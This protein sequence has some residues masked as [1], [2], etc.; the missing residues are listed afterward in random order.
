MTLGEITGTIPVNE[1]RAACA[2]ARRAAVDPNFG[3]QNAVEQFDSEIPHD[4]ASRI[5]DLNETDADKLDLA[6]EAYVEMPVTAT[7]CTFR[8][9]TGI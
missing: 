5:W 3:S 9:A 2:A 4:V 6:V 7:R 1:Y 8:S